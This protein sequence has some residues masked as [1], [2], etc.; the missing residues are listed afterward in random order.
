MSCRT[1]L[2][3]CRPPNSELGSRGSTEQ[4]FDAYFSKGYA[5][6]D[7]SVA[8]PGVTLVGDAYIAD[9]FGVH[10]EWSPGTASPGDHLK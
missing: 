5:L 1:T 8:E 6:T 4:L 9:G 3:T 2:F 10:L 7:P